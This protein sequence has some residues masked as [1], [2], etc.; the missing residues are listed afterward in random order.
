MYK[1]TVT[2]FL[3]DFLCSGLLIFFTEYCIFLYSNLPINGWHQGYSIYMWHY[4]LLH[5]YKQRSDNF[6]LTERMS[7]LILC[8]WFN[9]LS[10]LTT[11]QCS[12]LSRTIV[13]WINQWL[14]PF[15]VE[16]GQITIQCEF[17][18]S[19]KNFNSQKNPTLRM[20]LQKW[21]NTQV[22][23]PLLHGITQLQNLTKL[24]FVISSLKY[25]ND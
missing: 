2:I 9:I 7:G 22:L 21:Q 14:Q 23:N 18:P 6:S 24:G 20:P 11:V 10:N 25:F 1:F 15:Q 5:I 8:L 3:L 16:I 19:S 12:L 13:A 17:S 4:F